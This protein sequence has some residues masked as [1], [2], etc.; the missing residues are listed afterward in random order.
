MMDKA[1]LP[2]Q[3][4]E[5]IGRN[6]NLLFN[7]IGMYNVYHKS[8]LGSL[9]RVYESFQEG[10][11][12]RS[13]IV[14]SLHQEQLVIED[15]VLDS[16][17]NANRLT[18][19]FKKT[20]IQSLAFEVGITLADMT[21]FMEI[22]TDLNRYPNAD[23]MKKAMQEKGLDNILVNYFVYQKIKTDEQVVK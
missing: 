20:D 23:A 4:S 19:H 13:T 10:F 1:S 12:N 2:K 8:V 15:E 16:R 22:L 18:A 7:Q 3:L 17:I 5:T 6:F 11:K 14:L 9:E 21:Q